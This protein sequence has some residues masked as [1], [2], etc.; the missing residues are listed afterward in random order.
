MTSQALDGRQ[1]TSVPSLLT[2]VPDSRPAPVAVDAPLSALAEQH[3]RSAAASPYVRLVKPLID[4]S[5]AAV[6]LVVLLPLMLATAIAV[7]L[8]LGQ[9]VLYRQRRVGRGGEHFEVL[10]FRTMLPERRRVVVV[11][12]DERRVTHKTIADPRHTPLGCFLRR[13]SLDE[14]P[15]L[16]NVL[17][18][19]MS[20]V[21]PRPELPVVVARYEPWQE[22]RH[23]VKPGITGW[24]QV[25]A[26]GD[27]PMHERVDLDLAYVL[28]P[29]LA[30]D[31]RILGATLPAAIGRGGS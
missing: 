16:L 4:R 8:A 22:L 6:L 19:D 5:L 3:M 24:W 1:L 11:P 30:R 15:Q 27:A 17:K 10:K 14:L 9:P 13:W 21:G 29:T 20:L 18:G 26:R 2:A 23:L 7:L 25:N 31:L 28:R 12:V